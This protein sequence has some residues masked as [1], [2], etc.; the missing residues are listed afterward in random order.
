MYTLELGE[1]RGR[2]MREDVDFLS[3]IESERL[4]IR[5]P[6]QVAAG[7]PGVAKSFAIGLSEA[8][9]SRTLRTMRTVTR[10]DG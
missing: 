2:D 3:P 9:L 4:K 10:F 6:K 5:K 1:S 8:G 7:I